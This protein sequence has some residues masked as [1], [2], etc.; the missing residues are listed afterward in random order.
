[1]Y[2][3]L[4]VPL[5]GS[6]LAEQSL[7]YVKEIAQAFNSEAILLTVCPPGDPLKHVLAE[8]LE[9]K[10]EGLKSPK[11]KVRPLCIE[12]EPAEAILD[13]A[14]GNKIDLIV[15][16]THGKGGLSR[17][18]LG[19]IATKVVQR[20]HIPVFLVRSVERAAVAVSLKKVLAALDGSQ[21]A[22]AI[23]AHAESFARAMGG[24]VV[25]LQVIEPVK[26][27]Q[28][29]I[30]KDWEKVEK[31]LVAKLQREAE[32]YLGRKKTFLEGKGVKVGVQLLQGRPAET[33]LQYAAENDIDLIALTTH[34]FSGVTRW[35]Y[36]SV[37]SRVVEASTRPVLLV[38]PP[39]PAVKD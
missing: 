2:R 24:K 34:G 17:W 23:I 10:A 25:L 14:A 31:D 7:P 22:E 16:S 38:R 3:S 1:M 8:Y 33:I 37:A 20:S 27:P 21:F 19:S 35:A 4:L 12:G 39:L 28:L 18:P 30:Y 13:F 9:K 15:I 5:D 32:R 26:A 29:V 36:G 11:L 6:E